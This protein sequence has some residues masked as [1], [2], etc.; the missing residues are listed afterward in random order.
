MAAG[1]PVLCT[2]RGA[3]PEVAGGA[4]RIFDA[5]DQEVEIVLPKPHFIGTGLRSAVKGIAGVT[6]AK[7]R[8][9]FLQ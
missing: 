2:D 6:P 4:A 5:D 9:A 3:L 1:T 7:Y 8:A